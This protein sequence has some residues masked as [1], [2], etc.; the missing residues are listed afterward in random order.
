MQ[1]HIIVKRGLKGA[2]LHLCSVA[3]AD[4]AIDDLLL[5]GSNVF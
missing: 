5:A 3:D 1:E 2:P 4:V